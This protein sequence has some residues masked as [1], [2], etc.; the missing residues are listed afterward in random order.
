MDL[1]L[2]LDESVKS[3]YLVV[4]SY[5]EDGSRVESAIDDVKLYTGHVV[6]HPGSRVAVKEKNG[7]VG[8]YFSH[9]TQ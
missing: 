5:E 9:F 3:P 8:R 1:D 4:H 6:G 7:M 2:Q